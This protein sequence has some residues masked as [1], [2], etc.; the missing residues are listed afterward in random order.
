MV[1]IHSWEDF[2]TIIT[3]ADKNG[4]PI[5]AGTKAEFN[6][7]VNFQATYTDM[8]LYKLNA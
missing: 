5:D 8:M 2:K 4:S 3:F 1:E 6:A 7:R